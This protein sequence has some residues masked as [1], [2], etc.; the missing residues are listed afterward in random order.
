MFQRVL[1]GLVDPPQCVTVQRLERRRDSSRGDCRS[2][3]IL[4]RWFCFVWTGDQPRFGWSCMCVNYDF[5]PR[6]DLLTFRTIQ[7]A[8]ILHVQL[9]KKSVGEACWSGRC[10]CSLFLLGS[11][12]IFLLPLRKFFILFLEF[13]SFFSLYWPRPREELPRSSRVYVE[14]WLLLS[15]SSSGWSS[16]RGVLL[17]LFLSRNGSVGLFNLLE[18][19]AGVMMSSKYASCKT[20]CIRER[21]GGWSHRMPIV[22]SHGYYRLEPQLQQCM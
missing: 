1:F 2:F 13:Y 19:C 12:L 7:I 14:Q 17:H 4:P 8:I 20:Y 15:S 9:T 10:D 21:E 5:C 18:C 16:S 6:H 22:W 11:F 3:V